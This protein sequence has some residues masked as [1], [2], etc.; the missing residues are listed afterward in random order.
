MFK[1]VFLKT[2]PLGGKVYSSEG[3]IYTVIS[4]SPTLVTVRDNIF[5]AVW[6]FDPMLV[7]RIRP[8]DYV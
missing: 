6:D 8:N 3:Y 2:V 5:K 4:K 7:V 1:R